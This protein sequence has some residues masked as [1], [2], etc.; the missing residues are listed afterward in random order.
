MNRV[1]A[2]AFKQ[3]KTAYISIFLDDG[4]KPVIDK[5]AYRS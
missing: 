5:T 3:N 4:K 2:E 1:I